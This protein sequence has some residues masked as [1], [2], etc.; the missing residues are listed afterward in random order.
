MVQVIVV[1]GGLVLMLVFIVA[2]N[3]GVLE[4]LLFEWFWARCVSSVVNWV[5]RLYVGML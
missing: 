4:M 5:L 1:L 3:A 2:V